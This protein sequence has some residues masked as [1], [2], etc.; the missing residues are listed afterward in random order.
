MT[1]QYTLWDKFKM[2]NDY[3]SKQIVNMAKLLSYLFLKKALSL[4]ILKVDSL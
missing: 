2:L 3:S 1:I 4:S